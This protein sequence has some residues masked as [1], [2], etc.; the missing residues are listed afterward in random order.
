MGSCCCKSNAARNDD[1]IRRQ[2]ANV[3]MMMEDP[4]PDVPDEPVPTTFWCMFGCIGLIFCYHFITWKLSSLPLHFGRQESC[5]NTPVLL[6]WKVDEELPVR[7]WQDIYTFRI[8]VHRREVG[9]QRDVGPRRE[10]GPQSTEFKSYEPPESVL[11][12]KGV[13]S[14]GQD[15]ETGDHYISVT[16]KRKLLYPGFQRSGEYE[17]SIEVYQ[18]QEQLITSRTLFG[19]VNVQ[20]CL[21]PKF[22]T[23]QPKLKVKLFTDKQLPDEDTK[24]DEFD[25]NVELVVHKELVDTNV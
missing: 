19:I 8:Y 23:T 13:V 25:A 7:V 4:K 11:G 22:K 16:G 3:D 12:L 18:D 1:E 21:V 9:P 10:V 24:Q 5:P 15:E 17:F 2:M 6:T 20:D 14:I